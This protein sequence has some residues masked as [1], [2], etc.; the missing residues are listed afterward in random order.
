[1]SELPRTR[2]DDRHEHELTLNENP[3][4]HGSFV[5]DGCQLAGRGASYQCAQ[6]SFDLHID[7]TKAKDNSNPWQRRQQWFRLHQEA[8]KS[9]EGHAREGLEKART[10]LKEQC[11]ISPFHR[12][13]PL[14]NLACVEALLGH[15]AEGLKYLQEAVAAGWGDASHMKSDADLISLRE[16]DGFKALLASLE[17][18][19][20]DEMVVDPK[21][22]EKAS[23]PQSSAPASP[24]VVPLVPLYSAPVQPAVPKP[25]APPAAV[26]VPIPSPAPQLNPSENKP[27]SNAAAEFDD[28]L[29]TLEEM[30]WTDRRRNITALVL[31]RG[32][33]FAA[34][35][36]LLDNSTGVNRQ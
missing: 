6:C 10:L 12:M 29:K 21:P 26:P 33:L 30:G 15:G 27:A 17:A 36:Y 24:S 9:M 13:T 23:Q 28:K 2:R 3:Y 11:E 4:G 18:D 25:S 20:D 16:T 5:C 1:V 35:Q 34:V 14:Y 32:D 22:A 7:C 31:S 19:S 8:L